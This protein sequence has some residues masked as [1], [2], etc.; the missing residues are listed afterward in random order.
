MTDE[1]TDRQFANRGLRIRVM[2]QAIEDELL[3]AGY[4]EGPIMTNATPQMACL[5][6]HLV[7]S[8]LCSVSDNYLCGR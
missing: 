8:P 3:S 6:V 7:N 5:F 4:D 1:E 2:L